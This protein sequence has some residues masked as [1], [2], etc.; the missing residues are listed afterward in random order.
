V[1][2]AYEKS[3]L[4][5]NQCTLIGSNNRIAKSKQPFID[6]CK[7][8]PHSALPTGTSNIYDEAINFV[9]IATKFIENKMA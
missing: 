9:A 4:M 5:R 2:D 1:V 7:W 8:N 6:R 3:M